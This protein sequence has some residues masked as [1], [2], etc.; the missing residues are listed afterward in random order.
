MIHGLFIYHSKVSFLYLHNDHTW[1]KVI[2]KEI[3]QTF[4]RVKNNI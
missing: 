4:K 1:I 3:Q 2:L